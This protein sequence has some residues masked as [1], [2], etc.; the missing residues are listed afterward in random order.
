M[1]ALMLLQTIVALSLVRTFMAS[2]IAVLIR[3][4][5]EPA[6]RRSDDLRRLLM[7][8]RTTLQSTLAA[9]LA[10]VLAALGRRRVIRLCRDRLGRGN[11][12]MLQRLDRLWSA[13]VRRAVRAAAPLSLAR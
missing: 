5:A 10:P 1:I 7:D 4:L 3:L 11:C 2:K 12:G 8:K 13:I 9:M 6:G